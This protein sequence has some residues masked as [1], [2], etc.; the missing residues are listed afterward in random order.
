MNILMH[1][2]LSNWGL[3]G[4]ARDQILNYIQ[5]LA[6]KYMF[7][8]FFPSCLNHHHT[9]GCLI[10][11]PKLPV[12][13]TRWPRHRPF[14][15]SLLVQNTCVEWRPLHWEARWEDLQGKKW[16]CLLSK[17]PENTVVCQI[18]GISRNVW[19]LRKW[20]LKKKK[21]VIYHWFANDLKHKGL[22]VLVDVCCLALP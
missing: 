16:R 7:Q 2:W 17:A 21:H 19:T 1:S 20:F 11:S 18:C 6:K 5:D 3:V 14:D 10:R 12:L 8:T 15:G 13:E 9:Y 4:S 22:P